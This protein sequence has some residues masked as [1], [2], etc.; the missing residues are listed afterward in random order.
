M[1]GLAYLDASGLVKLVL[2]EEHSYATLLF[3]SDAG[4]NVTSRVGAVETVR[5]CLR[6]AE[7]YDAERLGAVLADVEIVELDRSTG[8][9][10]AYLRPP[11]LRTL[12]AVHLATAL[13]LAGDLGAFVTYDER[14]ADAARTLGLPVV[15][16]R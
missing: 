9:R 12:D 14:L 15:S 5:A 13:E 7:G 3:V 16:P 2:D 6:R 1:I 10:A 4:R 11:G 8:D